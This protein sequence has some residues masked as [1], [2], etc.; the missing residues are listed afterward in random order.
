MLA[1]SRA[2]LNAAV[3]AAVLSVAVHALLL[4]FAGRLD[5]GSLPPPRAPAPPRRLIVSVMDIRD[6]VFRPPE[7]T[8]ESLR[9]DLAKELVDAAGIDGGD[10]DVALAR[11]VDQHSGQAVQ[12][13]L[14]G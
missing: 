12:T 7:E 9:R 3:A 1:E 5:L 13:I 8:P 11:R 2:N 6:R 10:L 14:H 4:A